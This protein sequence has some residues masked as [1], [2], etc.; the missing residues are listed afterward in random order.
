[1][2]NPSSSP[3]TGIAAVNE[4]SHLR[5]YTQDVQGGIRESMYEGKWS[6]GTPKNVIVQ[7]KI[8]SPLAAC[9]K[10]LEEVRSNLLYDTVLAKAKLYIRSVFTTSQ[11]ITSCVSTVIVPTRAGM[12]VASTP[13]TSLLLLTLRSQHVFLPWLIWN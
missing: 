7:G 5:V 2:A 1:M 4:S 6:N 10:A 11:L 8:G 13:A 3:G 9:S 12:P